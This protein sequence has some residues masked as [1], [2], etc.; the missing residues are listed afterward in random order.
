MTRIKTNRGYFSDEN[1]V[2]KGAAGA[3]HTILFDPE[4]QDLES[5]LL[6]LNF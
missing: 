4:G 1:E 5:M 3:C 2:E 6:I